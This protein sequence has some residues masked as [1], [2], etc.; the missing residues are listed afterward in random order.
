MHVVLSGYY[1]FDNVGD[2]AILF[3]IIA[4][5]RNEQPDIKIT[6]LSNNPAS[7]VKTYQV[8]AINRHRMNEISR[9]IK[10]SD[11][12]ISG[13]GSLLQDV[14]G[15]K[16]IPYYTS[17]IHLARLHKKPVFVYAQGLGPIKRKLYRQLV[18]YTLNKVNQITVRDWE[19][20]QLLQQIGVR[21][22]AI[23]VPD[24]VLGLDG[25]S[26]VYEGFLANNPFIT[27]SVRNWNTDTHFMGEIASAL[28]KLAHE[29]Y[30]I[31]FVP[32]HGKHDEIASQETAAEM[33]QSSTIIPGKLSMEE[34][35]AIIGKSHLLIGMR[36]HALIFSAITHT[37]FIAISYDPK[38]DA[39]ASILEQPVAGHVTKNNWDGTTLY[40]DTHE[41]FK[42][43]MQTIAMLKQKV[44]ALNKNAV[45]TARLALETFSINQTND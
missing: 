22:N 38:I 43:R 36:L 3:A 35:V 34:K 14:T 41:N 31:V 17:I 28:D 1:G 23:L 10:E 4:A 33:N 24:P 13:G 27:V 19:S 26:F 21:Q 18:A 45:H 44:A 7:T 9:V 20:K 37:P 29:G 40:H 25:T 8:H 6:V 32:M 2:E 16:S 12:L 5:L 30:E 11:G 39:F 42:N 15:I